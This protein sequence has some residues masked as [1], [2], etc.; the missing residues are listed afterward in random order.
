M[1]LWFAALRS[2][3][4]ILANALGAPTDYVFETLA[5]RNGLFVGVMAARRNDLA[6]FM[7]MKGIQGTVCPPATYVPT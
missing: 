7:W 1:A 6:F 5:F 3:D 4:L 2:P